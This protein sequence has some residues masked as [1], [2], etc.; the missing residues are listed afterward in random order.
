MTRPGQV[1]RALEGRTRF[2]REIVDRIRAEVP[3]LGIGVR[4]SAFDMVPFRQGAGEVGRT[5]G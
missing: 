1:R 4:L 5:G 3:G 2:L